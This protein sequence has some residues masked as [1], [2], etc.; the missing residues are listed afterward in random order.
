MQTCLLNRLQDRQSPVIIQRVKTA[1]HQIYDR[2]VKLNGSPRKTVLGFA[3]GL[4]IGMSPFWG[5][6]IL[7]C[8]M[9][10]YALGWSKIAAMLG[11]NITNVFTAPLIYPFTYWVGTNL[12]GF[13]RDVK[14]PKTLN[15]TAFVE[16]LERS[17]LVLLD[18]AVG[19]IVLGVPLAVGGYIVAFKLIRLYREQANHHMGRRFRKSAKRKDKAPKGIS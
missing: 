18:L 10:A 8:L 13:T 3:L 4:F 7:L 5:L 11:V 19:G 16:L 2:F 1:A 14:W 12:A 9:V 15:T 6:H 17:P